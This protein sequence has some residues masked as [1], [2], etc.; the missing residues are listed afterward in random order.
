MSNE[1]TVHFQT[2]V[3]LGVAC[4]GGWL[5]ELIGF[6]PTAV[7]CEPLSLKELRTTEVKRNEN[8]HIDDI[9]YYLR[10]IN[11]DY[12]EIIFDEPVLAYMGVEY[13]DGRE[14]FGVFEFNVCGTYSVPD[15]ENLTDSELRK[16]IDGLVFERCEI[17]LY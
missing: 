8:R 4:T 12:P 9:T 1:R 3:R 16:M 14:F 2:S 15:G 17:H 13:F 6:I 5:R 10:Q 11:A 7:Q